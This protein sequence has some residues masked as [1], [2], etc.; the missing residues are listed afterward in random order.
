MVSIES[1]IENMIDQRALLS[2]IIE[3]CSAGGF[4]MHRAG[5][6][7][8]Y[9]FLSLRTPY[10]HAPHMTHIMGKLICIV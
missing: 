4:D 9:V 8:C 1:G 5:N 6:V 10:S 2:V 7:Q 3:L